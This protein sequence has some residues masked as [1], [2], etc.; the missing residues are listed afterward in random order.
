MGTTKTRPFS[1]GMDAALAVIGVGSAIVNVSTLPA[2][3]LNAVAAEYVGARN[4]IPWWIQFAPAAGL[5]P[6]TRC[7]IVDGA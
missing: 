2:T 5:V 3:D 7:W 6:S 1:C 4:D